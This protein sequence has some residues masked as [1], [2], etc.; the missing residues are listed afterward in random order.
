MKNTFDIITVGS[1]W[2]MLVY[3]TD[4][5]LLRNQIQKIF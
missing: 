1:A 2:K 4:K 3:K 5:L